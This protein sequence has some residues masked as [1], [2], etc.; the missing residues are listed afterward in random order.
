MKTIARILILA[1][2]AAIV[3]I[4]SVY[5]NRLLMIPMFLVMAGL[6]AFYWVAMF[7]VSKKDV[8]KVLGF[9]P[10]HDFYV[11]KLPADPNADLLR[12]RMCV[13]DGKLILMQRTEDKIHRK[14]PCREAWS[15]D[16]SEI[17]SLGFGK[18]LPARKG[19]VLYMGDDEVRFTCSKATKDRALI[20]NAL[21][22]EMPKENS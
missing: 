18:V 16:I 17:T 13:K 20:Y 21:G 6:V 9:E 11:G 8:Q 22:W 3:F 4:P 2:F 5:L 7:W 14:T 19:F 1:N 15:V 10:E 12:G